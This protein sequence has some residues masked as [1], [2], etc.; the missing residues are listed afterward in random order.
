MR[1][2]L[3]ILFFFGVCYIALVLLL[4]MFQERILFHPETLSKD[5]I[6]QFD[7][8]FEEF[9]L[10]TPDSIELNALHFKATAPRGVLLYFHG[11]KG[12]LARWGQVAA[13]FVDKQYD[14]VIMDYRGYGKNK[15][16]ITEENLY[17]D[18]QLFY[19]YVLKKYS[20]EQIIIYGRSLGTGIAT[21]IAAANTPANL[22][23]ETPYYN[24]EDV[25]SRWFPWLPIRFML[26]YK[27][28][29]NE[30]IQRVVCPV[31]IYHGTEDQ[32]V[33]YDSGKKLFES[34]TGV[35]KELI[36]IPNGAHN[37]LFSFAIYQETIDQ[38]LQRKQE[39]P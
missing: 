7:H 2:L 38:V 23:L 5:F 22:I 39:N 19:D 6:Y 27:L 9:F 37:N 32:V 26:R 33:P 15:G 34:I 17:S 4:S 8:D 3:K 18:A 24:I 12:N 21:N 36:T 31:T 25:A 14:V 16:K 1:K 29:S 28:P 13:F 35:Q 20:E 30:F 10:T 11:N